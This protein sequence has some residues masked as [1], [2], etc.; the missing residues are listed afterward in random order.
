MVHLSEVSRKSKG[1]VIRGTW[2]NEL[3]EQETGARRE[4]RLLRVHI[5][6][7]P[8]PRFDCGNC[9]WRDE[10]ET[11]PEDEKPEKKQRALN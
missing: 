3:K 8:N 6:T 9:D 11:I 7:T 4:V 2:A 5:G 1:W 10:M